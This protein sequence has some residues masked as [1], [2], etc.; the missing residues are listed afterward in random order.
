V[1]AVAHIGN[2][3]AWHGYYNANLKECRAP[4]RWIEYFVSAPI[5]MLNI[6]YTLGIRDYTLLIAIT[7]LVASTMPFGYLTEV[8]ARPI[9]NETWNLPLSTRLFPHAI[10]YI[11]QLSAWA[12]V[13]A[14]FYDHRSNVEMP[15]FVYLILWSQFA[16]FSSFGL[17]QVVQQARPPKYYYQGELAYQVG[18]LVAKSLLGL[19]L[20][21][22]VLVLGSFNEI[23]NSVAD[24]LQEAGSGG[25]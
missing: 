6:A 9:D 16:L 24:S 2:A 25:V 20:L 1:S 14:N 19:I 11:P 8:I 13:M 3:W 22:N 23:I 21:S 18:S 17:V 5:M 15:W 7:M 10:G 12:V 4:A